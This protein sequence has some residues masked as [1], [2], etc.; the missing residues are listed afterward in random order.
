MNFTRG[1]TFEFSGPV[2]VS[3][4]GV[5]T[6]DLTGYTATS[7]IRTQED[8][9]IEDLNLIFD[10]FNPAVIRLTAGSTDQ[11]PLGPARIDV[12][13]LTPSGRIISTETVVFNIVRDVTKVP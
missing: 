12:E 2:T 1:D 6:T 9:L 8:T 11:W 7:Q 5:E 10:S 4:N 13:F 3:V